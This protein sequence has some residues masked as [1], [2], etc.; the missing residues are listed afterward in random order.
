MSVPQPRV[1]DNGKS[2]FF[3]KVIRIIIFETKWTLVPF[4]VGLIWI[5]VLYCVKF[6]ELLWS[7]TN[8]FAQMDE[9]QFIMA[10]LSAID[11]VMIA[12]LLYM[13]V[14]GSYQNFVEKLAYDAQERV[15]SGML[16]V[17]MGMSLVGVSSIHLMQT[18]FNANNISEKEV[19]I[20]GSIHVIFLISTLTLALVDYLHHKSLS[21]ESKH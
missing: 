15:S 2:G 7:I 17:K 9:T 14:T 13:I 5:G 4:Y 8:G 16:K 20:K 6:I 19:W 1:P 18:F 10:V 12:N 3:K 11:I 21:L